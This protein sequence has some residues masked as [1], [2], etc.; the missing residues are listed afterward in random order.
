MANDYYKRLATGAT[1]RKAGKNEVITMVELAWRNAMLH[2]QGLTARVWWTPAWWIYRD[3]PLR[4]QAAPPRRHLHTP[5]VATGK[6][7]RGMDS[8]T[9]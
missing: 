9:E 6:W 1:A 7:S 2:K 8:A 5:H 4:H 3:P